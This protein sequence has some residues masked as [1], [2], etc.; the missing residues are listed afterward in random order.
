MGDL[1]LIFVLFVCALSLE[2]SV[3]GLQLAGATWCLTL[4]SR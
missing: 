2:T 4:L 3:F 1:I